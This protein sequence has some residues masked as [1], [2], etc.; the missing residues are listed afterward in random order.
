[1][2]ILVF[3]EERALGGK[4]FVWALKYTAIVDSRTSE[5]CLML[6]GSVMALSDPRIGESIHPGT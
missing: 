3:L 6:N 5:I 1:M 2:W 4:S